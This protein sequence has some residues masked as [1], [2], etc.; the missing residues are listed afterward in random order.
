[1]R[2]QAPTNNE[3]PVYR[4]QARGCALVIGGEGGALEGLAQ[5]LG[6]SG[7]SIERR[8][9][10]SAGGSTA[11]VREELASGRVGLVLV[12]DLQAQ[13]AQLGEE[14]QRL[15]DT[16]ARAGAL[17]GDPRGVF[18]PSLGEDRRLLLPAPDQG[19]LEDRLARGRLLKAR[20]GKLG[21][22][23]PTGFVRDAEGGVA[24][25]PDPAVRQAVRALF[26]SFERAPSLSAALRSLA[27]AGAELGFRDPAAPGEPPSWRPLNRQTL[28]NI[29]LN[30]AY[31][32][33]YVYGRRP[34]VEPP[35]P[36][37]WK[38]C[39][40]GA[41]PAYISWEQYE[42]NVRRLTASRSGSAGRGAARGG[43]ALLQGLVT[44]G[45]CGRRLVA[46]YPSGAARYV[47]L[48]DRARTGRQS[49]QSLAA[50]GVDEDLAALVRERLRGAALEALAGR[51]AEARETQPPRALIQRLEG[52]RAAARDAERRYLAVDPANARVARALEREWE[53][54][55]ADLD[56]LEQQAARAQRGHP[57]GALS[58]GALR[59]LAEAL[60]GWEAA[61][62]GDRKA[63][64]RRALEGVALTVQGE[65]ELV[66]AAIDWR[67]GERQPL[68]LRRPVARWEQMSTWPLLQARLQDWRAAGQT[69]REIAARLNGEGWQT[70]RLKGEITPEMVR[71]LLSRHRITPVRRGV[72]DD[73][74]ALGRDEWWL[75]ELARALDV[76]ASTVYGWLRRGELQ[77]RQLHGDQGRWV[78][79]MDG[80]ER[81]RLLALKERNG[82]G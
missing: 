28:R 18:D 46:Q 32:G 37:A 17:V 73:P 34:G 77:A 33:A 41:L 15:V 19:S 3:R 29:L 27:A 38:V 64:L 10:L 24:L 72:A 57:E 82:R 70:P 45:R 76:P 40:Q 62:P 59:S 6:W 61:R 75:P 4:R 54:R 44:C 48:G 36:G 42:R 1:M 71:S 23:V 60:E 7:E 21:I 52:A 43:A 65:T 81:A 63:L 20:R 74:E 53:A 30:P 14:G 25:D 35:S 8:R 16:C 9:S 11:A 55:L 78:V 66:A 31:A 39:L 12:P 69:A 47:C 49:C 26:G 80:G 2:G 22:R 79:S 50:R 58:E 51:R 5:R 13:L 67:W 68:V 56:A